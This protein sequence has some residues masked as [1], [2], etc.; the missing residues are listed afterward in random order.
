MLLLLSGCYS[1]RISTLPTYE[2][3]KAQIK[4]HKKISKQHRKYR[5]YELKRKK[6]ILRMQNTLNKY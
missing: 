2:G 3:Y 6:R 1:N 4:A 5:R